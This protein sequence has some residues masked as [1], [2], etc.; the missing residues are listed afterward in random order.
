MSIEPSDATVEE[1]RAR[2]G[3]GMTDSPTPLYIVCSPSRCVGKTL[4]SR[5]LTEFYALD[6]R[7]VAAFD[8][9]DEGPQLADY[10]PDF[11]EIADIGYTGGQMAFFDRLIAEHDGAT[12]IDVSHRAFEEFF[13]VVHKIGFFEEA[14]RRGI[15][16]LILFIA[17]PDPK[18]A[19]AFATL[20]H[21]FKDASL[22]LVRNRIEA[23]QPRERDA[24]AAAIEIPP[25][26]FSLRALVDRQSFSFSR[27]WRA[28]PPDLPDTLDDEL[29]DWVEHVL[30]QLRDLELSFGGDATSTSIVP[31]APRRRRAADRGQRQHGRPPGGAPRPGAEAAA[32]GQDTTPAQVLQFAPK[33]K[34]PRVDGDPMDHAGS[35][36]VAMLQ[37]ASGL[38]RQLRA[39]E[40]RINQLETE[41]EQAK[42]RAVRAE[43]WLQLI[44]K[45]IEERLIAPVA[46]P[47]SMG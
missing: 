7:P 38:A 21:W 26:A 25:L 8:L 10:L 37:E 17:D 14:R 22:L 20:R 27:Y 6:D 47:K 36:I 24:P 28:T 18:S 5:L 42:D 13:T 34:P 40:D 43:T 11:T 35:A 2:A 15:E 45:E 9:A 1:A 44:Q 16:P 31:A 39:A 19:K 32:L 46:G 33:K 3:R 4:V 41:I 29:R 30:L 12:I 23:A